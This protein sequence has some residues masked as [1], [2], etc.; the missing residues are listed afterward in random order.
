MLKG[1]QGML[2]S[3]KE[4]MFST[5]VNLTQAIALSFAMIKVFKATLSFANKMIIHM[6]LMITFC[7]RLLQSLS[8][9]LSTQT[10]D[11]VAGMLSINPEN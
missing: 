9:G 5:P 2:E 7:E 10:S 3:C 1:I 4:N 6:R 11:L 8:D